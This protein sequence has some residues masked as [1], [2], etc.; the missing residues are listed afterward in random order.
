MRWRVSRSMIPLVASS[1]ANC[2]EIR[3]VSNANELNGLGYACAMEEARCVVGSK[4]QG[5]M[6]GRPTCMIS[7]SPTYFRS[8]TRISLMMFLRSA[9]RA[10]GGTEVIESARGRPAPPGDSRADG[11]VGGMSCMKTCCGRRST[12]AVTVRTTCGRERCVSLRTC[13][14]D[15]GGAEQRCGRKRRHTVLQQL[16]G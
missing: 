2:Y 4:T 13:A 11:G 14:S 12:S 9:S 7:R 15:G 16:A 10:E 1:F 5:N 8:V 3:W 6:T